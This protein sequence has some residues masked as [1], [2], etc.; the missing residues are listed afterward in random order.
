MAAFASESMPEDEKVMLYST[1]LA[2]DNIIFMKDFCSQRYP[3]AEIDYDKTIEHLKSIVG[4]EVMDLRSEEYAAFAK[5]QMSAYKEKMLEPMVEKG[6]GLTLC[7][8]AFENGMK[9]TSERLRQIREKA[10]AEYMRKVEARAA[11]KAG[12]GPATKE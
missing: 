11:K 6:F 1:R 7:R 10:Y 9:I 5:Q 3:D 2:V 8:K 4:Q 12:S